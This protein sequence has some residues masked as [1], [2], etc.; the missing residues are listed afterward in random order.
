VSLFP[1]ASNPDFVGR[2]DLLVKLET[3]LFSQSGRT[4]MAVYGLGGIGKT[5]LV[6]QLAHQ[7]QLKYKCLVIWISSANKETLQQGYQDVA[8]RLVLSSDMIKSMGVEKAVQDYLSTYKAGRWLLVFDNADDVAMWVGS[9]DDERLLSYLPTN[10]MGAIV[11]TTRDKKTASALAQHHIVEVTEMDY[12]TTT[13]MLRRRLLDPELVDVDAKAVRDLLRF[14]A[15]LP[16]A[17]VQAASY[18]NKNSISL[19][20]YMELFQEQDDEIIELLSEGFEEDEKYGN[21]KNPV[22]TTWLISF[23]QILDRDSLAADYLSFMACIEPQHIPRSLLPH[24]ESQKKEV[25]A[26]GTLCAYSFIHRQVKEGSLDLHRLVHLATRSWLHT[27]GQL[28]SCT[29]TVMSRLRIAFPRPTEFNHDQ[30]RSY[31]PHAMYALD[32]DPTPN[33]RDLRLALMNLCARALYI[34]G[35]WND[36]MVLYR[37]AIQGVFSIEKLNAMLGLADLLRE[38]KNDHELS[39]LLSRAFE[40]SMHMLDAGNQDNISLDWP[41]ALS[42]LWSLGD[43]LF[44]YEKL[45]E[46]TRLCSRVIS[47][48]CDKLD[49]DDWTTLCRSIL[50][51]GMCIV[52]K[53]DVTITLLDEDLRRPEALLIRSFRKLEAICQQGYMPTNSDVSMI[54]LHMQ[55][56]GN[57]DLGRGFVLSV[58]ERKRT[59]LGANNGETRGLEVLLHGMHRRHDDQGR[60]VQS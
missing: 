52:V 1:F 54:A 8:Q 19:A 43:F 17:I 39:E 58:L 14:L 3:G 5:Q 28:D 37:K 15:Y 18:I 55:S 42:I 60:E 51:A 36:A 59:T 27:Q 11:F 25:D 53:R 24:G 41:Y 56:S 44:S 10:D 22:A 46:G 48:S 4:K 12:K 35:Q 32:H 16:L 21:R 29:D 20:E 33:D 34:D 6:I 47:K 9:K 40:K 45:K 50:L 31:L 13:L 38:K 2:E 57:F 7:A 30:W 26:I 23:S 49:K